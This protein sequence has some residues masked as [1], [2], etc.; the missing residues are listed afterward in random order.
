MTTF[1]IIIGALIA[2]NFLLLHFSCNDATETETPP[3]EE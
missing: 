2:C 3:D 1:L